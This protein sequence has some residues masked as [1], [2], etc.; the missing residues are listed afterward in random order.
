MKLYH[1]FVCT[2]DISVC[3]GFSLIHGFRLPLGILEHIPHGYGGQLLYRKILN[4]IPLSANSDF[5][6][7]SV[8]SGGGDVYILFVFVYIG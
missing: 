1:R 6:L 4:A 8:E 3:I 7:Q 5:S 2:G